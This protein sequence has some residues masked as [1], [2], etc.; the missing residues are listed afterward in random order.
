MISETLKK[1]RKEKGLTQ[2]QLA[3][4]IGVSDNIVRNW[5]NDKTQIPTDYLMPLCRV[6]RCSP[7]AF[8][9]MD[10]KSY[11]WYCNSFRAV[12][13]L[14]DF[15]VSN[16]DLMDMILYMVNKWDGNFGMLVLMAYYY[17]NLTDSERLNISYIIG[18]MF[19]HKYNYIDRSPLQE[20]AYQGLG[21]Y[22]IEWSK[23]SRRGYMGE[24]I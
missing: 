18:L 6:F 3:E 10:R 22:A 8:L 9:N 4:L 5:E 16:P 23:L 21:I 20:V 12:E 19:K 7:V 24:M 11:E 17:C 14:T 15:A 2:K 1:K 13:G